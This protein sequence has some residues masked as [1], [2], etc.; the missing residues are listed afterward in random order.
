MNR[1]K[2]AI[3]A[4]A[5]FSLMVSACGPKTPK[6]NVKLTVSPTSLKLRVGEEAT[7][8]AIV[9][10]E[11]TAVSFSSSNEKIA[12]VNEK[13]EV[14]AIAVG[15]AT[16]AVKA[17]NQ[18]KRVP[19]LVYTPDTDYSARMIGD[20]DNKL[21]PPFYIPERAL[22]KVLFKEINAANQPFGWRFSNDLLKKDADKSGYYFA[23]ITDEGEVIDN[24]YIEVIRYDYP[25]DN[26][27][28]IHIELYTGIREEQNPF[29]TEDGKKKIE[30]FAKA[31]GFTENGTFGGPTGK[32]GYTYGAINSK[33]FG[34][35][36][37]EDEQISI[38]IYA[39]KIDKGTH[40]GKYRVL[41][42]I[43]YHYHHDHD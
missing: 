7:I 40:E 19:V 8:K 42:N 34:K 36:H 20:K 3:M 24:R 12:T 26:Q 35:E 5:I 32:I 22:M 15:S 30:E 4:L 18:T 29:T 27:D 10:P 9:T 2:F 43:L 31:Y 37:K 38:I 25:Y 23:P 1:N 33:M 13:G 16:I 41:A 21:A 6:V 39:Q 28:F 14:K 11:S 17:G